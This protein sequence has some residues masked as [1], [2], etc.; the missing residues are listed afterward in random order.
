ML[1]GAAMAFGG[2]FIAAQQASVP[3]KTPLPV[4]RYVAQFVSEST[5]DD[6][7]TDVIELGKK[8]IL[9]GL[10]LA[11]SGSVAR[12]GSISRDYV[13]TLG[14]R[15]EDA[16]VMRVAARFAAFLNGVAM[17][18]DDYDD[19]H[20]AVAKDRV[21]GLLTHPTVTALAPALAVGHELLFDI[22]AVA[23]VG[24][25]SAVDF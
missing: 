24:E 19:T 13:E 17:H 25:L 1:G 10:G 6:I 5:F 21:H 20:L 9:D 2:Q 11:F 4:T 14:T 23:V 16:T 8:S 22:E 15:K 12:T 3:P 18:A 7:P